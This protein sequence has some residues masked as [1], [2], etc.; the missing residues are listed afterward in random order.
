MPKLPAIWQRSLGY[1]RQVLHHLR[2]P[3][4]LDAWRCQVVVSKSTVSASNPAVVCRVAN[5]VSEV[6]FYDACG[7][8]NLDDATT[9]K[10]FPKKSSTYS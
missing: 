1:P 4:W 5:E 6:E 3:R 8:Q 10:G 9:Q 7:G 2:H